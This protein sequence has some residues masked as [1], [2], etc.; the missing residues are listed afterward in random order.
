[1]AGSGQAQESSWRPALS[2]PGG[3]GP[4]SAR[5]VGPH[6][7][8]LGLGPCPHPPSL[9]GSEWLDLPVFQGKPEVIFVQN[10]HEL[11]AHS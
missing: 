2:L 11:Y 1:M 4:W 3:P 9:L 7:W 8:P 6:A 5:H 10:S